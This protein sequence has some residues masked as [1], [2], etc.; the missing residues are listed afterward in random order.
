[1]WVIWRQ[2]VP[3]LNVIGDVG[4]WTY[5]TEVDGMTKMMPITLTNL[6]M[7]VI[8]AAVT[9]MAARN[10][11]GVLEITVLKQLPMDEEFRRTGVVIAFPQRD[12][13][14]DRIGLLEVNVFS[15][16]AVQAA[17]IKASANIKK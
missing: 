11:P 12:V 15:H 13:H 8:L 6:V 17:E 5:S 1:M 9:F 7:A 2:G 4:L 14:L 16:Q 10:L 3:A